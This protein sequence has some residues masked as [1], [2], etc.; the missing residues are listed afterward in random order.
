[1]AD[2]VPLL[3]IGAGPFGLALSAYARYHN[4]EHV[5]VGRPMDYWKSQMPQGLHLRSGIDWHLDPFNEVT[6]ER[7]LESTHRK[8]ADVEPLSRNFY[9]DY[10]EWFQ[11]RK[12]IRV[13]PKLVHTLNYAGPT[14]SFEAVL[15]DGERIAARTVVV[16]LGFRYFAHM[17]AVYSSFVPAERFIHTCDLVDFT[18]LRGKRVLIIGGRQSAFEWAALIREHGAAGVC[19]SYRHRTPAFQR[20]DWSWVNPLVEAM[21]SDPGRFRRL[22]PEEKERLNRRFWSEGRLKLEPWL[23]PRIACATIRLFPQSHVSGCREL[24]S[25]ELEVTLN[26]GTV[27]PTD[28]VVLATGYKVDVKRIPLL[29]TS[30]LLTLLHTENGFPVLDEQFQSTVPGLFFTSM[31]ATRDFGPFFAFTAGVR[32]SAIVIGTAV[33]T[34]L[35]RTRQAMV[36]G[37]QTTQDV[38]RPTT[39][40]LVP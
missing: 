19:L 17:P 35:R 22:V 34:T 38:S 27:F 24:P 29:A 7:Y 6:I 10:C 37:H 28:Q 14:S 23:A 12:E 11:S 26:D 21:A 2:A 13:L 1:M 31:C 39:N 32:T 36:V 20:S 30:N 9:L 40:H 5:V 4:I 3:V 25:G 18:P 8:P 15:D 33:R 16:A